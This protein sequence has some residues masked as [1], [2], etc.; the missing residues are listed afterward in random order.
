LGPWGK[1]GTYD[2][3]PTGMYFAGIDIAVINDSQ[4]AMVKKQAF[5]LLMFNG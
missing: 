3:S 2:T 5:N 1:G 4:A